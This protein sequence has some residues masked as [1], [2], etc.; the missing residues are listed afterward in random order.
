MPFRKYRP[1]A[2]A[3]ALAAY[4]WSMISGGMAE[5]FTHDDL[6]NAGKAV[7]TP[8]RRLLLENLL[9]WRPSEVIRPFGE[10][11]YRLLWDAFGFNPKPYHLFC[12][13]LVVLNT[14]MAFCVARRLLGSTS[15]ALMAAWGLAFHGFFWGMYSNAGVVFDILAATVYLATLALALWRPLSRLGHIARLL[16]MALGALAALNSKEIAVSLPLAVAAV[17]A[18]LHCEE[19]RDGSIHPVPLKWDLA[20]CGALLLLTIPFAFGRVLGHGGLEQVP[21]YRLTLTSGRAVENLAAFLSNLCYG[22]ANWT[23]A[24]AATA[25]LLPPALFL[26]LR[27]PLPFVASLMAVFSFLPLAFIP[28][29]GLDAAYLPVFW[30]CLA[31]AAALQA[32]LPVTSW[33]PVAPLVVVLALVV[34]HRRIGEVPFPFFREESRS[35]EL[36]YNGI[37][38]ATTDFPPNGAMAI[39]EDHF[40]QK[41][42]WATTFMTLL[43][44]GRDDLV[45]LRPRELAAGAVLEPPNRSFDLVLRV[46][47]DHGVLRCS[48]A[49]GRPLTVPDLRAGAYGCVPV[50]VSN[51]RN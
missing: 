41:F 50:V 6:M 9:I 4:C 10:I 17:L 51:T 5:G 42:E 43:A 19:R 16:L 7:F 22:R 38:A 48:G 24:G 40:E 46:T 18:L 23:P 13:T 8:W 45:V 21:D 20:A 31:L 44:L 49:A 2:A 34:T 33:T 12:L 30:I 36:A 47:R 11:V 39:V 15:F 25:F 29:R 32:A 26:A 37:R 27:W 28:P 1:A 3:F 35:I 14:L